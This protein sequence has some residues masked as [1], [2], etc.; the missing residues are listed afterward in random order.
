MQFHFSADIRFCSR[1]LTV[2]LEFPAFRLLVWK[3]FN[4]WVWSRVIKLSHA[5]G[6]LICVEW[7][8]FVGS[9]HLLGTFSK[10]CWNHVETKLIPGIPSHALQSWSFVS[11]CFPPDLHHRSRDYR[12]PVVISLDFPVMRMATIWKYLA[13]VFLSFSPSRQGGGQANPSLMAPFGHSAVQHSLVTSARLTSHCIF[14]IPANL[15][16][17]FWGSFIVIPCSHCLGSVGRQLTEN[18]HGDNP[19]LN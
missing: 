1:Y 5:L 18:E 16:P 15:F 6:T 17:T 9:S 4:E 12:P 10:Q 11:V 8:T 7:A 13:T 2:G 3:L 14:L 19:F